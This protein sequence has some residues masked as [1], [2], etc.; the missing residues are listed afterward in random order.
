MN[1]RARFGLWA[2][3][4]ILAVSILLTGT[5]AR[6]QDEQPPNIIY[7]LADDLGYKELGS[8]GQ[9]KIKTPRLDRMA[10]EGMRFTQFYSG[11]P[12]C[13]P[14]RATFLTGKHTGHAYVRDNHELGGFRDEEERGQLPLPPSEKTVAAYLK[15]RGYATALVGKWG[16]GGPGSVG[17]PNRHGFDLFFGYLDQKQA[18]NFYP[19]HLW[20]N[21]TRFPLK[22]EFFLPHQKLEGDPGDP[23]SYEKYKGSEYSVDAMTREALGFVRA[24]KDRR[25]FLYFAPTLPHLAL[26]V[27]DS[28]LAQYAGKLP[29]A[30]Y[31]GAK[32]YLPHQTPRAAYAA[33]ITYLDTAVG[34]LLDTLAETGIDRRTI[35][36]FTSDNGATFDIGGADTKF[37]DSFGDLRGTKTDVY[38]GGIRV[39]MIAR[40]PSRIPGGATSAH[41]GANWDMW[42]TFAELAGGPAPESTDGISI[43]PTL[44]RR[45]SQKQ[46]EALY[47]EFHSKGSA[48]AVRMGRWKGVRENIA[49]EPAAAIALY[50]LDR[51]P[52]ESDD[53]SAGH[54]DV[55]KRIEQVMRQRTPAVL[56]KWNITIPAELS[57]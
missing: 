10:A 50:D 53:V 13:A 55:V 5:A 33:M 44:L 43:V 48:Q 45:G 17:Q 2:T 57:R 49:K 25:F 39:P 56:D 41:V 31:N 7:I 26:Q 16:L 21:E 20:R 24:N 51:D 9:K 19:T 12:V 11:S 32:G 18:H 15:E 29:D 6:Q 42:A 36:I 30:P 27:P 4:F 14:S 22:N 28:A 23:K 47:W 54:P 46:H 1:A 37:F 34:Q 38:E 52:T 35:V 8:Y 3:G 40:W